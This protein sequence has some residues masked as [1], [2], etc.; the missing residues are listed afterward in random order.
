MG[1]TN[2]KPAIM[3]I[4]GMLLSGCTYLQSTLKQLGYQ[5]RFENLKEMSVL[6]HLIDRETFYVYGKL[7]DSNN[8]YRDY[9]L[10]VA[11][12]SSNTKKPEVVD[13][14]QHGRSDSYYGL[15]L[16]GGSYDLTV[17]ADLDRNGQYEEEEIVTSYPV[18]FDQKLFPE[19][20]AGSID[21]T[22][23]SPPEVQKY[24]K[25]KIL[26]EENTDESRQ[27]LFY[28]K[29]TIR[30]L[31]D[32]IFS[33]NTVSMGM[34]EPAAFMEVAP[35]MFYA[36]EDELSYKIPVIFVHG[37]GG[38]ITDFREILN[39]LDRDKY[40]PWFFYYPSGSD[41]DKLAELFYRIFL[42]GKVIKLAETPVIIVAHSM[43]G[44]M[45]R[46]S[47]NNLRGTEAENNLEMFI[48]IAS[49]FGGIPSAKMG[50]EKAP[51]VLPAWRDL[52]PDSAFIQQLYDSPLPDSVAHH[53]F[54][55]F[56]NVSSLK[57]GEN[58]DGIVPL[59]SQLHLQAQQ[60]SLR[61]YGYNQGHTS[62]LS[63]KATINQLIKLI[64]E[65]DHP[66]PQ[67]HLKVM[68]KGG[69]AVELSARYSNL[70]QYAVRNYGKYLR[71]LSKGTIK[72]VN[73]SEESFLAA[74]KGKP[75]PENYFATAWIKFSEDYPQLAAGL[76]GY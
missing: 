65:V 75:D 7:D 31:D 2:F 56:G 49:P 51:L 4:T 61:Q 8:S 3:V 9:S 73:A 58:S 70:E 53:L 45:V 59:S 67:T 57:V 48:S 68:R 60:Q 20:V 64:A 30:Q 72:P 14:F 66:L 55:A 1:K 52:N 11:A 15:H 43:G 32:P 28:P 54:Y 6:K 38:S 33:A 27:S 25:L 29:G 21:I 12:I 63:D 39:K 62:I 24:K 37:I 23:A 69:F 41:L 71:A 36:L 26:V 40:K 22:I 47:I 34:Y 35:M 74:I 17:L 18:T 76:K 16:P 44:L 46:K 50:V 42:S 10:A 5:N 19:H 13:V